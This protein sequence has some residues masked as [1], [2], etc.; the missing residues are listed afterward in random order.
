VILTFEVKGVTIV[1]NSWTV[2]DNGAKGVIVCY[3]WGADDVSFFDSA[4]GT[5]RAYLAMSI[6][7]FTKRLVNARASGMC[8]IEP[9]QVVSPNSFW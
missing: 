8:Q 4:T 7:E 5:S 2:R 3:I 6:Q 9:E 1:T